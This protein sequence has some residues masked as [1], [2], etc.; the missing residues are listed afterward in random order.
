MKLPE[1]DSIFTRENLGRTHNIKT[2][3][4]RAQFM[5]CTKIITLQTHHFIRVVGGFIQF[6][7]SKD[8]INAIRKI[9]TVLLVIYR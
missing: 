7:I 8:A 3:K 6:L 2:I 5:V 4:F 9:Q 1:S